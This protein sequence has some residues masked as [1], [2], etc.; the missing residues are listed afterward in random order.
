MRSVPPL[1]RSGL[2]GL[3]LAGSSGLALAAEA[4]AG[5]AVTA[6]VEVSCQLELKGSLY[7]PVVLFSGG[8]PSQA[9]PT[10]LEVRCPQGLPYRLAFDG[11]LAPVNGSRRMQGPRGGFIFYGLSAVVPGGGRDSVGDRGLGDTLDDPPLSLN[12]TGALQQIELLGANAGLGQLVNSN[13]APGEYSDL[14]TI[15]LVY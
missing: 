10:T 6:R 2:A 12:G 3:L 4:T 1:L 9:R 15:T 5:F 13:Y 7:F 14:V 8:A 11:G